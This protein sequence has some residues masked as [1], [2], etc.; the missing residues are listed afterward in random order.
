MKEIKLKKDIP[1]DAVVITII[2][3]KEE[4]Q[5]YNKKF[6][7]KELKS[8]KN[9]ILIFESIKEATKN[10]IQDLEISKVE[11]TVEI[12]KFD[13]E[14]KINEYKDKS[15]E[16]KLQSDGDYNYPITLEFKKGTV[17]KSQKFANEFIKKVKLGETV[18]TRKTSVTIEL[19]DK[20]KRSIINKLNKFSKQGFLQF[21]NFG[22]TILIK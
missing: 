7:V 10:Y 4:V 16:R 17:S 18:I 9:G 22:T 14:T 13:I 11:S 6:K 12:E 1:A 5:Q 19:Y 2:N 8:N 15:S 21:E 3:G 20:S